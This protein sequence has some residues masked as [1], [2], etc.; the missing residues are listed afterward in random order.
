MSNFTVALVK[1]RAE[2]EYNIFLH[3]ELHVPVLFEFL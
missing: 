1:I 3:L 2:Q